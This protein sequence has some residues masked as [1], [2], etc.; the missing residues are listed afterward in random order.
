MSWYDDDDDDFDAE[1]AQL[2]TIFDMNM[3]DQE[4]ESPILTP[5]CE[6]CVVHHDFYAYEKSTSGVENR[7]SSYNTRNLFVC[8]QNRTGM[9]YFILEKGLGCIN[10]FINISQEPS[11]VLQQEQASLK[12]F[13]RSNIASY[14]TIGL[15]RITETD[16]DTLCDNENILGDINA[17][18]SGWKPISL[19]KKKQL[20]LLASS[21]ISLPYHQGRF[22]V[23]YYV[24]K[25]ISGGINVDGRMS[26]NVSLSF[27]ELGLEFKSKMFK[28]VTKDPFYNKRK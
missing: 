5:P 17:Y 18:N 2:T 10:G 20:L 21:P 6:L 1:V 27:P 3:D 26:Q 12:T 22:L 19:T 28:L 15:F 16:S 23:S 13:R 7:R 14:D 11:H 24:L 9:L 4:F 8:N 25:G